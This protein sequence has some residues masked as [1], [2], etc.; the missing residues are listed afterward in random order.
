MTR[1]YIYGAVQMQHDPF[2][3]DMCIYS[4]LTQYGINKH[5]AKMW[6]LQGQETFG[7]WVT[8]SYFTGSLPSSLPESARESQL[9]SDL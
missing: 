3:E 8:L 5:M 2:C 1:K 6:L 9:W 4:R 7:H